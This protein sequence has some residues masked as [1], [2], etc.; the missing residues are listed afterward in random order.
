MGGGVPARELVARDRQGQLPPAERRPQRFPC[1]RC[2]AIQTTAGQRLGDLALVL[3]PWTTR[4]HIHHL[5]H[6]SRRSALL[7]QLGVPFDV[8]VHAI[9][10][11]ARR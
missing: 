6:G 4:A 7:R 5:K 9:S 11:S 2:R 10:R 8:T 3:E 1:R